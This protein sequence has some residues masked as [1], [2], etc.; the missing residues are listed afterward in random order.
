MK[1][2]ITDD[3]IIINYKGPVEFSKK[4]GLYWSNGNV[5]DSRSAAHNGLIGAGFELRTI[6]NGN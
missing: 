5:Y 4:L 6:I 1:K 2:P 3:W